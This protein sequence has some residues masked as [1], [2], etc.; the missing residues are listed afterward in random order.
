MHDEL[1][2]KIRGLLTKGDENPVLVVIDGPAGAGK[3]TLAADILAQIETKNGEVIH[4]DD[5]YNGW[6]DALTPTLASNLQK[7][8]IEPIR[9]GVMPRYR[10]YDWHAGSYSAEVQLPPSSIVILE[11]VGAALEIMTKVADLSIWIDIPEEIGL[12]RVLRRDGAEIS[13]QMLRWI[14]EQRKFFEENHNRDNCSI[15]L[16]YGAPAPQ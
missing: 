5:L 10:R 8:I 15:H 16:P 14:E 2:D 12:E 3:T 6:E 1:F 9:S 7:W 4:C 11:G 13:E